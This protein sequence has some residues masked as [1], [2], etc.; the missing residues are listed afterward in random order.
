MNRILAAIGLLAIVGQSSLTVGVCNIKQTK[1]KLETD[2]DAI[3]VSAINQ[4]TDYQLD[5]EVNSKISTLK[6]LIISRT[7]KDQLSEAMKNLFNKTL[8]TLNKVTNEKDEELL[9]IDLQQKRILN[10]RIDYDYGEFKNQMF[11]LIINID[12]KII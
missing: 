2:I 8:F 5:I 7:I 9:D 10:I 6:S 1:P 11:D 3:V 4:I 12:K